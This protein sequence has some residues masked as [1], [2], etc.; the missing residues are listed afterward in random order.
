M[1]TYRIY[2]Y[3][4]DEM[5]LLQK[6]VYGFINEMSLRYIS[7]KKSYYKGFHLA[8]LDKLDSEV[9]ADFISKL[10][11]SRNIQVDYKH[12]EEQIKLIS[13]TEESNWQNLPLIQQGTIIKNNDQILYPGRQI[14]QTQ[15]LTQI[16]QLET[17]FISKIF[18]EWIKKEPN[19]QNIAIRDLWLLFAS[20]YNK[21]VSV[22]YL[23]F[24]SNFEYF[25]EEIKD[26]T[27]VKQEYLIRKITPNE[28]ECELDTESIKQVLS[29]QSNFQVEGEKFI[30]Q[31][32][33]VVRKSVEQNMVDTSGIY[34]PDDF[35]DRHEHWSEF[36]EMFYRDKKFITEYHKADFLVYRL[37]L[38]VLYSILPELSISNLRKEKISGMVANKVEEEMKVNWRGIFANVDEKTE[39]LVN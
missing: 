7:V 2:T 5:K 6:N 39:G 30:D 14:F 23:A 34:F 37:V 36:H 21:G 16:E 11:L 22:G 19:E 1:T 26:L 33:K 9:L 3:S 28:K 29:K 17:K 13:K 12:I 27:P 15:I 8:I 32:I 18:N 25:K 20:K 4:S 38:G 31:I 35:F 10:K 24:R